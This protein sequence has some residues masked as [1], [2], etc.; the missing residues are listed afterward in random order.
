MPQIAVEIKPAQI[1]QA[2]RQMNDREKWRIAKEI[3]AEQFRDTVNKFRQT[4]KRKRLSYKQIN[5]IVQKAREEFYAKS[6]NRR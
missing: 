5:N 3:I 6:C 1:E 4:I 2:I